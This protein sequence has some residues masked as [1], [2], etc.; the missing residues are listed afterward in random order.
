MFLRY[1]IFQAKWTRIP[2][3][4]RAVGKIARL[5]GNSSQNAYLLTLEEAKQVVEAFPRLLVGPCSCRKVF[6][7]CDNPVNVEIMIG[8]GANVFAGERPDEYREISHQDARDILELCH[9]RHLVPSIVRCGGDFYA[10]CNCCPCC[11]VPLRLKN[12]YHIDSAAVRD[13]AVVELFRSS[14]PGEPLLNPKTSP[15]Q[16][17]SSATHSQ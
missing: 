1:Y 12:Q 4:G 9:E 7:N 6:R 2:L 17:S 13:A 3:L 8:T 11:C 10:I 15:P 14:S 16:S 5:Y